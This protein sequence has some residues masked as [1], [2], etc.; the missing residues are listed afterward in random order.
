MTQ[1]TSESEF[2][3]GQK[4]TGIYCDKAF[5]GTINKNTRPTPDGRNVI[6]CVDCDSELEIYGHK[7]MSVE[8]WTNDKTGNV[9][10]L[11]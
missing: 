10:F 2:N 7:T 4:V 8:V 6:F 9:L 5:T 11:N 1:A 3:T